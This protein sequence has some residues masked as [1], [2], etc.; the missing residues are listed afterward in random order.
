MDIWPL[1][2][3]LKRFNLSAE[4]WQEISSNQRFRSYL[5]QE[6][7]AWATATNTHE[8]V[9]LKSGAILED[10]LEEATRRLHDKHEPLNSKVGLA[11]A[12]GK[13]AG[14]GVSKETSEGSGERFTVQINLGGGD[15][16]KL[17]KDIA[18]QKVIEG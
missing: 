15:Q 3:I 8:R 10:W 6:V 13:F 7:V 12:L 4:Q 17:E 11:T 2:D 18:T 14:V 9:K 1:E 5:E 16:I